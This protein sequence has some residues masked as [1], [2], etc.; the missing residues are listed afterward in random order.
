MASGC[1]AGIVGLAKSF[2]TSYP[3]YLFAEL[4]ETILG[5]SVYPSAFVLSESANIFIGTYLILRVI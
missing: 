3:G 2:V 4:L 1:G 5:A